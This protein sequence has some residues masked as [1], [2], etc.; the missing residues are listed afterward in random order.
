MATTVTSNPLLKEWVEDQIKE[1]INYESL[2]CDFSD[3]LDMDWE[4]DHIRVVV[5]TGGNNSFTRIAEFGSLPAPGAQ[6]YVNLIVTTSESA[7]QMSVSTRA[8]AASAGAPSKGAL[9]KIIDREKTYLTKDVKLA[10]DLDRIF[11][12]R[13][14]GLLNEHKA[15]GATAAT[16]TVAVP[17]ASSVVWEYSGT[18]IPFAGVVSANAA[19]WVRIRLFRQDTYAEIPFTG[20][21]AAGAAIFVSAIDQ[22]AQT[23]T[24]SLVCNAGGGVS[25]FTTATVGAGFAIALALHN[26]QY[27]DSAAAPFGVAIDT[28]LQPAGVFTNLCD[29]TH[30]TV[31]RTTATGTA[32]GLQG[33]NLTQATAG[34]HARAAF[35]AARIQAVLDAVLNKVGSDDLMPD[36]VI[37]NPLQR[38]LFV[39]VLTATTQFKVNDGSGKADIGPKWDSVSML[40][41]KMKTSQ[42]WPRGAVAFLK[43]ST[44]MQPEFKKPGFM[45]LDGSWLARVPGQ[46]GYAATYQTFDNFVCGEP[47]ANAILTGLTV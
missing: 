14:K 6:S 47:R 15:Q 21:D 12:G 39:A 41:Y 38:S 20:A 33:N 46:A 35:T 30:F 7:A 26:T 27:L 2:F 40:G 8:V 43:K 42:H 36:Y 34:G 11:G 5:H 29:P 3:S 44:W 16:C 28:S 31:D 25:N 13:D 10:L 1:T 9:A 32:I 24:I 18:F 4:G 19:T 23:V 37:L 22:S 17:N 45:D